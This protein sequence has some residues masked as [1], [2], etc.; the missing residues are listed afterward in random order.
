MF[1]LLHFARSFLIRYFPF[2]LLNWPYFSILLDDDLQVN[3]TVRH[4]NIS[5]CRLF[6]SNFGENTSVPCKSVVIVVNRFSK[7]IYF[8]WPRQTRRRTGRM[9]SNNRKSFQKSSPPPPKKWIGHLIGN[10][11]ILGPQHRKYTE[12]NSRFRVMGQKEDSKKGP[13]SWITP[14]KTFLGT[15]ECYQSIGLKILHNIC[16]PQK[17]SLAASSHN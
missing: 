17:F 13:K 9:N 16:L 1:L 14:E 4:F 11:K 8:F 5:A 12:K 7:Q 10:W 15:S 2:S 3:F 6:S